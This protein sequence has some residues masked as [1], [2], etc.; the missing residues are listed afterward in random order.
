[1]QCN[2]CGAALP[3]GAASCPVCGNPTPY[4]L[5]GQTPYDP[6]VAATPQQETPPP[7]PATNYGPQGGFPYGTPNMPTDPYSPPPVGPYAP[8]GPGPYGPPPTPP[9]KSN[10]GK[11]L[12][13]TG[14]V[15]LVI[16]AAC[17]GGLFL[18]AR[19]A[20]NTVVSSINATATAVAA[21]AAAEEGTANSLLTPTATEAPT[22]PASSNQQGPSPS[23][24][25][26]VTSASAIVTKVQMADQVKDVAPTHL[27]STFKTHQTIYATFEIKSGSSGYMVAKWY[28]NNLH[29]FDNKI[30]QVKPDYDAGYFAG[31][32]NL[33]GQGAVEIYWCTTSDCS[34]AQLAQVATFT[35]QESS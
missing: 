28:L 27:T 14:V 22:T 15:L 1:M 24:S 8:G 10:L 26:I 7:P 29:A 34:D 17:C 35:V 5:A 2:R 13:I 25:P 11:V 20:S 6:T 21:T 31:Y 18:L 9:R 4:N 19:N 33:A 12:L 3:T 23:G 16:V 30:L 32:Y